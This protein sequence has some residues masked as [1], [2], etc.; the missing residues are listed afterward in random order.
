LRVVTRLRR[1]PRS[2]ERGGMRV[3]SEALAKED[4]CF[5][6]LRRNIG[7]TGSCPWGSTKNGEAV[8]PDT[9]EG[10]PEISSEWCDVAASS[11]PKFPRDLTII[12]YFT[13]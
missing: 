11:I 4:G 5:G 9:V 10:L 3:S 2:P 13:K 12:C 8:L 7:A 6:G 1:K